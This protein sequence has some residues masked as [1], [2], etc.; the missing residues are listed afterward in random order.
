M[1][2]SDNLEDFRT[3]QNLNV[4]AL[5]GCCRSSIEVEVSNSQPPPS[6]PSD[7]VINCLHR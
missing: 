7:R 3:L 6:L 4:T 1:A 2:I 5:G